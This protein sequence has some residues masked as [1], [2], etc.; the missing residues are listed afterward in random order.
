MSIRTQKKYWFEIPVDEPG[1][2]VPSGKLGRD[3][4]N[5]VG[6]EQP[7]IIKPSNPAFTVNEYKN[8]AREQVANNIR[9]SQ[10]RSFLMDLYEDQRIRSLYNPIGLINEL[11]SMENQYFHSRDKMSFIPYFKSLLNRTKEYS[12]SHSQSTEVTDVLHYLY[13]A[14]FQKLAANWSRFNQISTIDLPEYLDE[15]HNY[16]ANLKG[17]KREIFYDSLHE[18]KN[19]LDAKIIATKLFIKTHFTEEIESITNTTENQI[20][21][22]LD[23]LST[24]QNAGSSESEQTM[25]IKLELEQSMAR[26]RGLKPLKMVASLLSII[27]D[28]NVDEITKKVSHFYRFGPA[29]ESDEDTSQAFTAFGSSTKKMEQYFMN[30]HQLF[31]KQLNDIEIM[32]KRFVILEKYS[33]IMDVI[34]EINMMKKFIA[35]G[36][37]ESNPATVRQMRKELEN[38]LNE[39]ESNSDEHKFYSHKKCN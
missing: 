4:F 5:S 17:L 37:E 27:A 32:L 7:R 11:Q 21:R 16:I 3:G 25:K 26:H 31:S 20:V 2:P 38:I 34:A 24:I 18:Y 6:I 10:I 30:E 35:K 15:A 23:E 14:T 33:E 28:P 1:D 9:A 39:V 12:K 29:N 22:L 8:F 13:T 36:V 19:A